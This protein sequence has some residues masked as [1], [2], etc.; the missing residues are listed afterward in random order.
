M[1]HLIYFLA[2]HPKPSV[3]ANQ[4]RDM[5]LA[6]AFD[7][8]APLSTGQVLQGGPGDAPGMLATRST[9]SQPKVK[10]DAAA[11]TWRRI[12]GME[13]EVWVGFETDNPPVPEE[14]ARGDLLPGHHMR[15]GDER[16][17]LCPIA[18]GCK[19]DLDELQWYHALPKATTIDAEGNWVN[20]G[21]L[22]KYQ[23]LWAI[24]GAYFDWWWKAETVGNTGIKFDFAGANDAALVAL[25]TNYHVGRIEVAMLSLFN[26]EAVFRVLQAL[27]DWPTWK[28]C[29][30]KKADGGGSS[31]A[32]G[33]AGA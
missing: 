18:R 17:W 20:G 31:T 32:D 1:A 29:L 19:D 5:G 28:A 10:Y 30:K 24:A 15:L 27:I 21:V 3:A 23:R 13:A 7:R 4:L 12:P 33:A 9:P 11:Q 16:E 22:E 2:R 26:D 25:A 8:D 14:M 6:Y